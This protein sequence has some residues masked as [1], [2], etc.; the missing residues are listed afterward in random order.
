M[1][2]RKLKKRVEWLENEVKY[3]LDLKEFNE[4]NKKLKD[5][6]KLRLPPINKNNLSY[7]S[8][9]KTITAKTDDKFTV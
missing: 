4:Q 2:N 9:T 3:I 1:F 6:H 8:Q 7:I 5:N